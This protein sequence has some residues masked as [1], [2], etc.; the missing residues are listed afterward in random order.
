MKDIPMFQLLFCFIKFIA[1]LVDSL[2]T[3]NNF[4]SFSHFSLFYNL[5]L[6]N[7]LLP[8]KIGAGGDDDGVEFLGSVVSILSKV[9]QKKR[10]GKEMTEE[11]IAN[12]LLDENRDSSV[13]A[14]IEQ[15]LKMV[16]D[17]LQTLESSMS[18]QKADNLEFN[19]QSWMVDMENR[20]T[21][22]VVTDDESEIDSGKGVSEKTLSTNQQKTKEN[23]SKPLLTPL[24]N[25]LPERL[26]DESRYL[27][28]I[29]T[30]IDEESDVKETYSQ[31]ILS[32]PELQATNEKLRKLGLH[33]TDQLH[34]VRDK[35]FLVD[36]ELKKMAKGVEFALR[37]TKNADG[38]DKVC[39]SLSFIS[40]ISLSFSSLLSVLSIT[41]FVSSKLSA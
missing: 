6:Q 28:D 30:I 16:E 7:H 23:T 12:A 35:I 14:A 21:T 4:L 38:N 8:L 17:G 39:L 32:A 29:E 2:F 11:L 5:S 25:F 24:E 1:C 13:I 22:A 3:F 34:S 37:Q 27:L 9:R 41:C 31:M 15:R 20:L 26:K 33:L 40:T 19:L 10:Y 36:R 18:E